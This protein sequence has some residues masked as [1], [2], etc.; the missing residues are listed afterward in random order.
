MGRG[1]G[2][3]GGS[4]GGSSSSSGR[5]RGGQGNRGR[6]AGMT[7]APSSS[8]STSTSTSTSSKGGTSTSS[9]SRSMGRAASKARSNAAK[10][11][12][13][14]ASTKSTS[15]SLSISKSPNIG[16]FS[17]GPNFSKSPNKHGGSWGWASSAGKTA[18]GGH[19]S[20]QQIY[21]AQQHAQANRAA[22]QTKSKNLP[23]FM[24]DKQVTN[25]DWSRAKDTAVNIGKWGAEFAKN[26]A[27]QTKGGL[28]GS[29]FRSLTDFAS[30]GPSLQNTATAFGKGAFDNIAKATA[31]LAP[32]GL[33]IARAALNTTPLGKIAPKNFLSEG[34]KLAEVSRNYLNNPSLQYSDPS[35][36]AA[37]TIGSFAPGINLAGKLLSGGPRNVLGGLASLGTGIG[38]GVNLVS[39]VVPDDS[40]TKTLIN[41]LDNPTVTKIREGAESLPVVG[42]SIKGY[43]TNKAE[44]ALQGAFARAESAK[45]IKGWWARSKAREAKSLLGDQ[46]LTGL[47]DLSKSLLGTYERS[48]GQI[49]GV[50]GL[51]KGK[52]GDAWNNFLGRDPAFD[53]TAYINNPVTNR[54]TIDS[55]RDAMR[56]GGSR[57]GK[58]IVKDID[59]NKV[60]SQTS[61]IYSAAQNE[62]DLTA[63]WQRQ[64]QINTAAEQRLKDIQSD[65][66][67]Y[68][69]LSGKLD[70]HDT[71]YQ[72][73]IDRLKPY[74]QSYRDE[75]LRIQ[76]YGKEYSDELARLQPYEK[77]FSD[78]LARIQ[79]YGKQFTDELARL[80]PFD[81]EFT[82]SIEELTKNREELIGYQK[83]EDA[84]TH[85]EDIKFLHDNIPAYTKAI[86]D[87]KNQYESYKSS[88]A[89]LIQNQKNYHKYL[90]DTKS[91]QKEYRSYL[92]EVQ[93]GHKSYQSYLGDVQGKQKEYQSYLGEI[94]TG[95]QE[96][97][98]YIK[99]IDTERSQL[100]D[101]SS[102]FTSAKQASDQAARS[103][104]VRA[105]QGISGAVR[106][107]VSG[108]RAGGGF[109]TIG[110]NRDKSPKRRFNR[111][112]R[113]GS[114]GD[115]G[116]SPINI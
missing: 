113:I 75:L 32:E 67:I 47:T 5:G 10:A 64:N 79:P 9:K 72:Q 16:N 2:G 74:G 50:V 31:S 66:S 82:S 39:R 33:S 94:Q 28:L 38:Q 68:E 41:F 7:G 58:T 84:W 81:K 106:Q 65:R 49:P 40:K 6:S 108:V 51:A 80:Q 104:T 53:A 112:F 78:E 90:A 59:P 1:G 83:D 60:G 37:H 91:T 88:T 62:Q 57:G 21:G 15:K 98:D 92:G 99:Q 27:L 36:K 63:F 70:T 114:F 55:S 12:S 115:T 30:Q 87:I 102:A 26:T 22:A 96:L 29:N 13:A 73:E 42:D 48:K 101:Y 23:S 25:L 43:L 14:A 111:D 45:G 17:L 56:I 71:A 107:G 85:P 8:K 54:S 46:D 61:N 69:E 52:I 105:Q 97:S 19:F 116:M 77:Q 110:S 34:P 95:R 4:S 89:E 24:G 18:D 35:L 103:Y 20:A 86:E 76:P 11:A 93:E 100:E 109:R 44:A 3:G